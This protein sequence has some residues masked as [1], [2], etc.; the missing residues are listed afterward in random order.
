MTEKRCRGEWHALSYLAHLESWRR[1]RR[2]NREKEE[3]EQEEE[4]A[5]LRLIHIRQERSVFVL[6]TNAS[7]GV[8]GRGKGREEGEGVE[9]GFR[10]SS[11]GRR[12]V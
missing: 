1:T 4:S 6:V 8:N 7:E 2:E 11:E 12:C 10:G 5:V 9:R 3:R